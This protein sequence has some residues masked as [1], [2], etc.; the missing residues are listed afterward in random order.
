MS[1]TSNSYLLEESLGKQWYFTLNSQQLIEYSWKLD[2]NWSKSVPV[3][4]RTVRQFSVTIDRNDS[5]YLLAYNTSKQLIYYE[6]KEDQWY[7]RLLFP[8]SSRFEII[9]FLDVISTHYHIHLFYYIENS[10]KR[11]Q[12]SLVHSYLKDGKWTSDVL[13]NFLTDQVVTPQLIRSDDK[14]NIFCVYTRRIQNQSRCYYVYFD[15]NNNTW[16]KPS[17]LFQKSGS[18]CEFNGQTDSSGVL[19]LVWVEEIGSEYRLNYKSI[20][21]NDRYTTSDTICIQEGVE[22]VQ[23]PSLYIGSKMFCFWVQDGRGFASHGDKDGL[24]W[25]I[26][27]VIT[28]EPIIKYIKITKTLDGKTNILPQLGDGYPGFE[29]TLET[30]LLGNKSKPLRKIF[31]D[32]IADRYEEIDKPSSSPALEKMKQRISKLESQ[33]NEVQNSLDEIYT[34]L[35]GLQ[36]YIRQ[37]E[38]GSFQKEA[39]I[40]KLS[41]E[42][43][44]IRS[45]KAKI[46]QT[47]AIN[48]ENMV[49]SDSSIKISEKEKQD[50]L[51][52]NTKSAIEEEQDNKQDLKEQKHEEHNQL[53][54]KLIEIPM[55]EHLKEEMARPLR[56]VDTGSGEIHL[57]GVSIL[58]NPED[59]SD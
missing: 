25:E 37:K 49:S 47:R 54:Q 42:L 21:P 33:I 48:P 46:P 45:M 11:A 22:L 36:D 30:M 57:G 24:H 19:H 56:N 41:F 35:Q 17:T 28:K 9:S 34:A 32:Q 29:W 39:Q 1:R 58:I 55:E 40:R 59:D 15:A 31:T 18:F 14:S 7:Q 4:N 2:D 20:N 27:Q 44:Q 53:E 13:L 12:E 16:S 38:K 50:I 10:L 5:I 43:E 6:W 23:N 3:D 51:D 52:Q 26:P 8:I